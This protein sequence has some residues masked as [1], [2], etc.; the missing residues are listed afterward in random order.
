MPWT[1]L[2]FIVD[3]VRFAISMLRTQK[4]KAHIKT[5][6]FGDDEP[7]AGKAGI[8]QAKSHSAVRNGTHSMNV[9]ENQR[10]GYP[11]LRSGSF[12]VPGPIVPRY[13]RG[14]RTGYCTCV[15]T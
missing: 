1:R 7:A 12:N 9:F 13:G 8:R 14:D 6:I 11:A 5:Q 15:R 10:G 4:A 3:R 2:V